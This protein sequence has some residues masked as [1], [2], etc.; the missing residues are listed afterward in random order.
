MPP[1]P[2]QVAFIDF[3]YK[4]GAVLS[5]SQTKYAWPSQVVP[6]PTSV[7]HP[8]FTTKFYKQFVR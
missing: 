2:I 6:I 3:Q 5:I 4:A 7:A 1:Y 8:R